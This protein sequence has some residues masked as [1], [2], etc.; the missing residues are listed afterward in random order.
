MVAEAMRSNVEALEIEHAA[1][2]AG[3]WV[4]ISLGVADVFHARFLEPDELIS[5]ADKALYRAKREGRNRVEVAEPITTKDVECSCQEGDLIVTQDSKQNEKIIVHA[6]EDIAD[7]IPG[8]LKNRRRDV[9]TLKEGLQNNDYESIQILGHSMK[10]VG[11]GYGFDAIAGIGMSI[12]QAA[13]EKD[14]GEIRK[15]TGALSNYLERVEVRY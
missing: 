14:A 12:E 3:T 11:G 15:Q 1:S 13:K 7:L 2:P 4:T 10:G 8:F 6:D 9:E 5:A